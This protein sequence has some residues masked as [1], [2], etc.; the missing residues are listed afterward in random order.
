MA[1]DADGSRNSDAKILAQLRRRSAASS[2]RQESASAYSGPA[3]SENGQSSDSGAPTPG[4][5]AETLKRLVSSNAPKEPMSALSS[6]IRGLREELGSAAIASYAA[7]ETDVA[8]DDASLDLIESELASRENASRAERAAAPEPRETK[9]PEPRVERVAPEPAAPSPRPQQENRPRVRDVNWSEVPDL[10][11]VSKLRK[12]Y[13]KGKKLIPVLQGVDV[14]VKKGELLAVVGQSG[15][16]KSTLL[17]LMGTLD[18]PDSGTIHFDGQR[19]DNLPSAQRDVLRNRFIGMIFQ[20]YHLIPEMTTLENVLAPLMIRCSI[21]EYLRD[22]SK[23][24]ARAKELLDLVGLSHRLRHRPNELSGGEMQRA[25]IARALITNP[26]VL[27]ADEPTG[28]LDSKASIGV[29]DLLRKLNEEQK[30]TIV[31]VT[32]DMSQAKD[33]DRAIRLV[34]GMIVPE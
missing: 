29:L 21:W 14:S 10:L 1:H 32:H 2:A 24:V 16:G 23:Y 12:G 11:V 31:M 19:I 8:S 6:T 13:V 22:R 4:D 34:D 7:A 27:L 3:K 28:N 25:S 30:L 9:E 26:R 15:S 33:A 5:R 20:F 18:V 17:H